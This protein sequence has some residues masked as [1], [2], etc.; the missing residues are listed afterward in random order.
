MRSKQLLLISFLGALSTAPS[1][2]TTCTAGQFD[3]TF[4][5]IA[6]GGYVQVSPWYKAPNANVNLEGLVFGSDNNIYVPTPVAVDQVNGPYAGVLRT[7]RSGAIDRGYGGFGF[8][9]PDGQALPTE[10]GSAASTI[11]QDPNGNL[12]AVV[13]NSS[14]FAVSRFLPGGEIDS[15]FGVAGSTQVNQALQWVI[16]GVDTAPDGSVFVATAAKNPSAPNREQPVVVKLSPSGALDPA[17]G[18]GGVAF[19]Y[20]AGYAPLSWGRAR[21]VKRLGNGDLVISGNFRVPDLTPSAAHWLAYVARLHG[22]GTLDTTFGTGGFAIVD[23]SSSD[24][25]LNARKLAIQS[26]GKIVAVGGGSPGPTVSLG[27]AGDVA[28]AYRFRTDGT[29]DPSFGSGGI[30]QIQTGHCAGAAFVAL[31][32]NGKILASTSVS[33]DETCATGTWAIARL[34]TSGQLDPVFGTGGF[35]TVPPGGPTAG[36]QINLASIAMAGNGK[37]VISG[38]AFDQVNPGSPA[39]AF[40][41][42]VDAG[43]GAGCR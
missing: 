30:S 31:Q 19:V 39:A 43:T 24:Q 42:A 29:L 22:D 40:L 14:G 18:V 23:H 27:T 9:A 41:F 15:S 3:T 7:S 25:S 5:P 33:P 6:S 13:I 16:L 1:A 28:I 36:K 37:I 17:F 8:V 34:T 38:G 21:D 10:R 35:A 12:I 4:G 32:N 26:D 2:Q 11:A 20:P